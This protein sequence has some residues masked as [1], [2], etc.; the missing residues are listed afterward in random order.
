MCTAHCIGSFPLEYIFFGFPWAFC[1]RWSG[2]LWL[3][4]KGDRPCRQSA[5][6]IA[7]SSSLM[8]Q[9]NRY[10]VLSQLFAGQSS[11]R[12]CHVPSLRLLLSDMSGFRLA[13][14]WDGNISQIMSFVV[15]I[16]SEHLKGQSEAYVCKSVIK[17]STNSIWA[18]WY[19]RKMR[20]WS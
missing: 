11:K 7:Y 9:T 2:F 8:A 15:Q 5:A 13:M 6:G 19:G 3:S 20:L 18:L 12:A 4:C 14:I 17:F 1:K 10:L 16:I